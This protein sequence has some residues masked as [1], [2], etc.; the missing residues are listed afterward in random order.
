MRK[1]S[2]RYGC[3][4]LL[5]SLHTACVE[6]LSAQPLLSNLAKRTLQAS[7]LS[8]ASHFQSVSPNS[9]QHS[10]SRASPFT[11]GAMTNER[12]AQPDRAYYGFCV[13]GDG[14]EVRPMFFSTEE[15]MKSIRAFFKDQP[16]F[17]FWH[18]RPPTPK[19]AE[20]AF[21]RANKNDP[22]T[23]IFANLRY[24]SPH[25]RWLESTSS[26]TG[27]SDP[28]DESYKGPLLYNRAP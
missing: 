27:P 1:E 25:T 21:I 8:Y 23:L 4:G 9:F 22:D 26:F 3:L 19:N 11:D 2:Y 16:P 7:S 13:P 20:P 18:Y 24:P 5:A 14:G 10:R 28:K 12:P 17:C 15:N 6:Y